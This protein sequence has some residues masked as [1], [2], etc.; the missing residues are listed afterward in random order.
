MQLLQGNGDIRHEGGEVAR[1][2]PAAGVHQPGSAAQLGGVCQRVC[3]RGSLPLGGVLGHVGPHGG[4]QGLS[5][6]LLQLQWDVVPDPSERLAEGDVQVV[7]AGLRV[8]MY[9]E[10]M[11]GNG[12]LG[13]AE[14][15]GK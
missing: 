1:G 9:V 5:W 15:G 6:D 2:Q 12:G 11:G 13:G 14:K 3:Y 10:D 7:V 8:C 4:G